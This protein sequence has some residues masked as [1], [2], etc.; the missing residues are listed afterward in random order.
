MI[1]NIVNI[2][3]KLLDR[4]LPSRIESLRNKIDKLERERDAILQSRP[5]SRHRRRLPV[6]LAKL[7]EAEQ[8]LKNRVR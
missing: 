6:V 3:S 7:H 5:N 1:S 4:F 2:I 8:Q